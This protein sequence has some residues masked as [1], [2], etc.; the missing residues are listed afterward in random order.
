MAEHQSRPINGD[1][2]IW[3]NALP[4]IAFGDGRIVVVARDEVLAAIQYL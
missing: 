4:A 1:F 3:L 2:R